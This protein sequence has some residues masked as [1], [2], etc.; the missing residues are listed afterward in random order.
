MRLLIVTAWYHPFIHPRAHRWTALAE[1][2]A[3][4]GH[5]IHV[6]CS[7]RVGEPAEATLN[8]VHLHRVGFDSLK[9]LAYRLTGDKNGRGR[10]GAG[11]QA[12]GILM[13][14]G[15]WLY[16]TAWKSLYFPDDACIWY[17]PAKRKALT[18]LDL[19][20]PDALITVSLP[21]TG[22]LIGLAARKNTRGLYW[23]ADMGDPFAVQWQPLNN[24]FLYGRLNRLLERKVLEQAD[25]VAVTTTQT[26]EKFRA[27]YGDEAVVA[28]HIVPPLLHPLPGV[29]ERRAFMAKQS[30][31]IRMAYFGALYAPTRTP[32]AFLDLMERS[33][34]AQP[35]LRERLEVHFYGEI[36]P[37]FYGMLQQRPFIHLH[38][39]RPRAEVRTVMQDMDILLNIGNLSDI[40]LPS[41]AVEYLASGKPVVH[42]S[43]S[44]TDP[45]L[46]FFGDNKLILNLKVENGRVG[47]SSLHDWLQ[48]LE[49]GKPAPDVHDLNKRLAAFGVAVLANTYRSLLNA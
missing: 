45:F 38:G 42:L 34:A 31:K 13:R 9:E 40:Q 18:L 24:A 7:G 28:M 21:F 4:E 30:G 26:K 46:E 11:V 39:L 15:A 29:S 5:E 49:A 20:E 14:L 6:L 22:H 1:Q 48:W 37:E 16:R 12:P 36:F 44:E 3:A 8:G 35:E 25:A 2:W 19:L 32:D 17:W 27:H 43:Y 41:K 47:E 10:V 33:F 23:L